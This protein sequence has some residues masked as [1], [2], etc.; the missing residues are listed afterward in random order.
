MRS[1]IHQAPHHYYGG[2]TPF[3]YRAVLPTF[4]LSVDQVSATGGLFRSFQEEARRV[5]SPLLDMAE[6]NDILTHVINFVFLMVFPHIFTKL[7]DKQRF[8][9]FA[10]GW[11][12]EATKQAAQA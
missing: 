7:D 12:V 5:S 1:G 3:F 4:D 11:H 6:G 8:E 10:S 9:G 2:F